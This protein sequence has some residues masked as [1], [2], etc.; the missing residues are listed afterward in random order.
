[1]IPAGLMRGQFCRWCGRVG[2]D[3]GPISRVLYDN[4][5]A[6]DWAGGPLPEDAVGLFFER[7]SDID[8]SAPLYVG[9]A[10]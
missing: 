3:G 8:T 5:A 10:K 1:M 6:S 2:D 4:C 9:I 7:F